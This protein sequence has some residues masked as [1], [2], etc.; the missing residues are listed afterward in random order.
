[1]MIDS[2]KVSP[3]LEEWLERIAEN[4]G[5][6]RRF[7]RFCWPSIPLR[8]SSGDGVHPALVVKRIRCFAGHKSLVEQVIY[9][10]YRSGYNEHAIITTHADECVIVEGGLYGMSFPD[11][12]PK[13]VLLHT[14]PPSPLSAA[15]SQQ[16]RELLEEI[17]QDRSWL[18]GPGGF[19]VRGKLPLTK[20]WR[21]GWQ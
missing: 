13:R 5:W 10:A 16:D 8:R 14:H 3:H 4:R 21:S 7:I 18:Y 15:A 6:L 1:M 12:L 9:L 11:G 2:D 17:G 19:V 20:F